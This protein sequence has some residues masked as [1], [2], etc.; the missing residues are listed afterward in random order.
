MDFGALSIGVDGVISFS[1]RL[2]NDSRD[3]EVAEVAC[4]GR[5]VKVLNRGTSWLARS[6]FLRA[7]RAVNMERVFRTRRYDDGIE[8][9]S[10]SGVYCWWSGASAS[11]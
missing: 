6:L 8:A 11:R 5:D 10:S 7:F 4:C 3:Q 2:K 1:F 9:I